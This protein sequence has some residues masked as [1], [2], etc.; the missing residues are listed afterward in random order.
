MGALNLGSR[1]RMTAQ[2][3][4]I[5]IDSRVTKFRSATTKVMQG[6]FKD[7]TAGIAASVVPI[8]NIISFGALL[9]PDLQTGVPIAIWGMLI[10]SCIGGVWIALKTSLPPMASG[11]DSPTVAVLATVSTITGTEMMAAGATQEAAVQS[12]MLI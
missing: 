1:V 7:V 12:V 8:A 9:F 10:G 4:G 3:S 6:A 2:D 5:S 11:M